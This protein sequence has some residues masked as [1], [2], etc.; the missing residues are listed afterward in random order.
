MNFYNIDQIVK[1]PSK[2]LVE[3]KGLKLSL[4]K[5]ADGRMNQVEKLEEE[6]RQEAAEK[7]AKAQLNSDK[8][9]T[10]EANKFAKFKK[11]DKLS[12]ESFE[13]LY[14][15]I[16]FEVYKKSL[17]LDEDFIKI[18]ENA[19]MDLTSQMVDES[20]LDFD[21][22]VRSIPRIGDVNTQIDVRIAQICKS[23]STKINDKLL[24]EA[25]DPEKTADDLSIKIDKDTEDE[26]N[27]KL[28]DLSIDQVSD[29]IKNKVIKVVKD[30]K[31]AAARQEE[32]IKKAEEAIIEDENIK[33]DKGVQEALNLI[34]SRQEVFKEYSLFGALMKRA[35]KEVFELT[36]EGSSKDYNPTDDDIEDVDIKFSDDIDEVEDVTPDEETIADK[37][38]A[39]AVAY[40][41]M[42]ETLNTLNIRP[43]SRYEVKKEA[44]RIAYG[45]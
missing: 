17:L 2:N 8:A 25:K 4:T 26:L 33:D 18:H 14:K 6:E 41:T 30:E 11:L 5:E 7:E 42:Y 32:D 19:L 36:V 37:A 44:E 31:E 13:I 21:S 16:V 40:Y 10:A 35:Y 38:L 12:K 9:I 27:D 20:K 29:L 1:A 15:R 28:E 34:L 24:E 45:K 3:P 22:I 23:L 39:E 43:M